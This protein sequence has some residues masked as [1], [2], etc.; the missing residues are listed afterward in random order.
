MGGATHVIFRNAS[1]EKGNGFR[2]SFSDTQCLPVVCII[3]GRVLRF[4]FALSWSCNDM[5]F[6]RCRSQ[7]LD[8]RH[9]D[10]AHQ[11]FCRSKTHPAY[12]VFQKTKKGRVF[13]DFLHRPGI[14]PGSRPWQ[15]R[16]LPLDQRCQRLL[17]LLNFD[18]WGEINCDYIDHSCHHRCAQNPEFKNVSV[19]TSWLYILQSIS[20]DQKTRAMTISTSQ[21]QCI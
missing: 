1:F 21:H 16:I 11:P 18:V 15:G 9:R 10:N 13:V 17:I 19:A 4:S 14:E 7:Q 5:D 12:F 8:Q 2:E 3:S 6:V 20:C